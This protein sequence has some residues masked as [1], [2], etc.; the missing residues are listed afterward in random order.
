ML[1]KITPLLK[2]SFYALLLG[3]WL[4]ACKKE[5]DITRPDGEEETEEVIPGITVGYGAKV[6]DKAEYE[7]IPLVQEPQIAAGANSRASKAP[8]LPSAYDLSSKMPPVLSQGKQG[9]CTAWAVGYAALSYV[10]AAS[11]GSFN[12]QSATGSLDESSVHS[13]AYIYNQTK[14]TDCISGAYLYKVLDLIKSEGAC[15]LK[16]MAYNQDNCNLMPTPDQKQIASAYKIKDWG[17][18]RIEANT[19]RK[20]LYYDFPVIISARLDRNFKNYT[21]YKDANGEYIWSA[22][23]GN[24]ISY[25]AMVIA[26]YDDNRK[27]F[28]MQNSWGTSWANKGF[29]WVA[30]D[31]IPEVIREAYVIV[32]G[33]LPANLI[34]PQVVTEDAV[35]NQEDILLKGRITRLGDSPIIRYG[36]ATSYN[37]QQPTDQIEVI[38]VPIKGD[39]HEFS[40]KA[41]KTAGTLY[42]RAFAETPHE[43]YYG[44]TKTVEVKGRQNDANGDILYFHTQILDAGNGKPIYPSPFFQN[45]VGD[46]VNSADNLIFHKDYYI[47][48]NLST[49]EVHAFGRNDHSLK[50][51]QTIPGLNQFVTTPR[52]SNDILFLTTMNGLTAV[53]IKTGAKKWDYTEELAGIP[54]IKGDTVY[55][56]SMNKPYRSLDAKTGKLIRE[57]SVPGRQGRDIPVVYQEKLFLLSSEGVFAYNILTGEMIWKNPEI[58]GSDGSTLLMITNGSLCL[59]DPSQGASK[60]FVSLSTSDGSVNWKYTA[61]EIPSYHQAND[62]YLVSRVASN[63]TQNVPFEVVDVASGKQ[64]WKKEEKT[65]S[66]DFVLAD[67]ILFVGTIE[68]ITAYNADDG[69]VIWK[70]PIEYGDQWTSF[71][72]Y[73]VKKDGKVYTRENRGR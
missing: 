34:T 37:S 43:V 64:K 47:I 3:A 58:K 17:R 20:F 59:L 5:K 48:Y 12:Y 9:S 49:K 62:K 65:Y 26:G 14:A 2:I 21:G 16:D 42:F 29:I 31:I 27:A 70:T 71:K 45:P 15:K 53:D 10:N 4:W 54:Y 28:K 36:I 51:K 50:W 73:L 67:N 30:Y 23:S 41:P 25:H 44:D 46:N 22:D 55:F 1:R 61:S 56:G 63:V 38:D 13:P 69:A 60:T 32:P 7:K 24:D 35:A 11:K 68:S 66:L 57:Y 6:L 39:S 18:I 33:Q 72:P 40:L 8:V 19:F 52:I